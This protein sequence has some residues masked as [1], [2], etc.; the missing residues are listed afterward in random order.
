MMKN[1]IHINNELFRPNNHKIKYMFA[2]LM[3][4]LM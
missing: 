2:Y 3:I 4:I 1:D